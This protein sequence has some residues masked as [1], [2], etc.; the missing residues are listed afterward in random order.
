MTFEELTAFVDAHASDNADRLLLDKKAYPGIDMGMVVDQIE[1]RRQAVVKWPGLASHRGFV[2]PPRINREQSSSETTA[3]YKRQIVSALAGADG[4]VAD[5]TGGMGI[6]AL[7]MA[8]SGAGRL[9]YVE[10]D[11]G[12]CQIM[13]HNCRVLGIDNLTVFCADSMEWLKDRGRID[14]IYADPSRRD[15]HGRRVSAFEDCEPDILKF[16]AMLHE[17]CGRLVVK[18]SPMIDVHAAMKQLGDVNDVYV[19]GVRGEC[20]EIVFVCGGME[21]DV[22]MHCVDL[23]AEG[24]VV[25]CY[26]AGENT[27]ENLVLASEVGKYL[28]LPNAMITKAGP[29]ELVGRKWNVAALARNTHAYT[30]DRMV[31]DFP[32]RA[33]VVKQELALNK[34][35]VSKAVPSGKAH[36]VVRNFPQKAAALQQQ[37]GLSEGGD[38]FVVAVTVGRRKVG[39]LCEKLY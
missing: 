29:F 11:A 7:C 38:L 14:V 32:G 37:L 15:E 27:G 35:S 18:A 5:L 22:V 39:L 23:R 31:E 1:G 21:G 10:R 36:V 24:D 3:E 2:Y 13:T 12:L 26:P 33:F 6:D 16:G 8:K 4:T 34:K 20:K 30:S 9:F 17:H 25:F 28:Y 19:I